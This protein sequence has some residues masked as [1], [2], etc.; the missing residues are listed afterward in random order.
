MWGSEEAFITELETNIHRLTGLS[1]LTVRLSPD[2]Y[3][4]GKWKHGDRQSPP[5]SS[6][7]VI[8]WGYLDKTV[9]LSIIC[10]TSWERFDSNEKMT[11]FQFVKRG[12]ISHFHPLPK[13]PVLTSSVQSRDISQRRNSILL[14]LVWIIFVRKGLSRRKYSGCDFD[15]CWWNYIKISGDKTDW[16]WQSYPSLLLMISNTDTLITNTLR[17][18]QEVWLHFSSLRLRRRE[19]V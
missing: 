13:H 5:L 3:S 9:E 4:I 2:V 7:S 14:L 18:T 15:E 16:W 6:Y 8:I 11:R 1:Y 17:T 12:L 19:C 10:L